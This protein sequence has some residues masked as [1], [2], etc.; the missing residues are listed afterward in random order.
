[1]KKREAE[2]ARAAK[3]NSVENMFAN[4]QKG[5]KRELAVIIKGDV[6]GSVEAIN[7]A[8][9]KIAEGNEEVSVRAIHMGVGAI[10]ESD[11]TLATATKALIIGFNVRANPQAR[12][13]AR[14]DGIDIR[15]YS[16]IY[17][18]I[19]DVKALLTGLLSPVRQ[20]NI[21]GY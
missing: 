2:A 20:E 5:G 19:D 16:I 12:D 21:I 14:R 10:N 8:L 6:F 7:G 13:L 17:N 11:I 15:Y 3:A 18:A 4:L 1:R 9:A